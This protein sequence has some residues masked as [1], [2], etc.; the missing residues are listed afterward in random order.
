MMRTEGAEPL[1]AERTLLPVMRCV[2]NYFETGMAEG[3]FRARGGRLE[4]PFE[5]K[6]GRYLLLRGAGRDDR[7]LPPGGEIPGPDRD[8]RCRV[9][10]LEP[11]EEFEELC[12]RVARFCEKKEPGGPV[13]ETLGEYSVQHGEEDWRRVFAPELMPWLRMASEVR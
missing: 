12:L 8:I 2:H 7:L 11:P 1:P 10:S 4:T 9:W 13:K 6:E 5:K 3:V